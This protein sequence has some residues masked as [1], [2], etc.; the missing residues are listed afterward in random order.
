VTLLP[1]ILES[2]EP[3][4]DKRGTLGIFQFPWGEKSDT[5]SIRP[6]P[7][8]YMAMPG[9]MTSGGPSLGMPTDARSKQ[10][11]VTEYSSSFF[12][13]YDDDEDDNEGLDS[14]EEDTDDAFDETTLWEIAS[15][16][17]TDAVPSKDSLLPPPG[18][19]VD[20][21]L[22]ELASDEE[23]PSSREQSIVIGL[24]EP[25]ELFKDQ[26]RD[27]ATIESS[28]LLML[29]DALATK[30]PPKPAVRIGLPAN[31][32]PSSA[33]VPQVRRAA[34][35]P[36]SK[37][38][39]APEVSRMPRHT[40]ELQRA[41]TAN[42]QGSAGLWH[43]PS[44]VDKP[45]AVGGLLFV[46]EPSRSA[47]RGTSEEPAAKYISCKPRPVEQKPMDRLTST[48]LWTSE[49][50]VK[51]SQRNWILGAKAQQLWSPTQADKGSPRR[52]L[53]MP[54]SIR[55]GYRLTSE[56]PVAKFVSR[57]PRPAEQKP[58]DR[59]ASTQLWR[60]EN[61]VKSQRNWILGATP[62]SLDR[63]IQRPQASREDWKSALNKAIAASYPPT[64]KL[65]RITATPAQWKAALEE[66]IS[67]PACRPASFNSAI[68]HPVFAA[69]SL[70]TRSEWFHPAATGYTYDVSVVHPV[71]FGSLAITCP[72]EAV[73]PAISAYAAKKVRR[74]RSRYQRSPDSRSRS[75]SRSSTR[76]NKDE[77]RAQIRALEEEGAEEEEVYTSSIAPPPIPPAA[78]GQ[79]Q[80][81]QQLSRRSA[82]DIQ[83]QI[84]ALEQERLFVERAAQ[85][86]YRRRTTT[87][88]VDASV[89]PEPA[90]VEEVVDPLMVMSA[91]AV[92]V[93]DLQRRLSQRIRQSLVFGGKAE[94]A[95]S[96]SGSAGAGAVSRSAS[97][98]ES[99]PK[100]ENKNPAVPPAQVKPSPLLWTPTPCPAPVP[101]SSTT[102]GLWSAHSS[103]STTTSWTATAQ[104][105]ED[106]VASS[107][108]ARRRRVVQKKQ[109]RQEILAQI[110]AVESGVNPFVDFGGMG[111][112]VYGMGGGSRKMASERERGLGKD[113]LHSVCERRTR[114]VVLRY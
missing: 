75:R 28:T 31:P 46:P 93:Q 34:S 111:L 52:A 48:Q 95:K 13:D 51:K 84:E 45:S 61:A 10:P 105:E 78:L 99:K 63:R 16:L 44:Q 106:T 92:T 22:D 94:T 30:T 40:A 18:S 65:H 26:Q 3:L 108:R 42:R 54:G 104:Q 6:R 9:T 36:A 41:E 20:D 101:S 17:K 5:A 23:G 113:W 35:P 89:L 37:A 21:Y 14:D 24:G 2:P 15:L 85:E 11:E 97:R 29:E 74:Q 39:P 50:A 88:T 69:T 86:E 90:P 59:L 43:P 73:H 56:E 81:Q 66:A 87:A 4:P 100:G 55:S 107:Q 53:F 102:N 32:K 58:L 83:A 38:T 27:S 33:A 1:D 72:E 82:A 76:R 25:R 67:L 12:D 79:Q 114:G 57:K 109:R 19:V 70:V 60:F 98:S 8:M 49:N 96:G 112:W 91:G 64:K 103:S 77:I 7:S 80:G 62:N 47:Y 110:A 68:R 71:F